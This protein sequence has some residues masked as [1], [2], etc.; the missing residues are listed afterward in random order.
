MTQCWLYFDF[1]D[2]IACAVSCDFFFTLLKFYF[3]S[4]FVENLK[5]Y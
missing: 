4:I 5:V 3:L 2:V 1:E